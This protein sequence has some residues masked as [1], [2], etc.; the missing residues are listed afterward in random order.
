MREVMTTKVFDTINETDFKEIAL[1]FGILSTILSVTKLLV[2]YTTIGVSEGSVLTVYDY[3]IGPFIEAP[4]LLVITCYSLGVAIVFSKVPVLARWY[5]MLPITGLGVVTYVFTNSTNKLVAGIIYLIF[6]VFSRYGLLG[7][8]VEPKI[9]F[10]ISILLI[11]ILGIRLGYYKG[12][13]ALNDKGASTV[14]LEGQGLNRHY[15]SITT[16]YNGVLFHEAGS[17]KVQFAP[18]G[19]IDHIEFPSRGTEGRVTGLQKAQPESAVPP[20]ATQQSKP[21]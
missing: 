5:C 13:D 8:K 11:V 19:R 4:Y 12:A 14:V 16:V 10:L 21:H 18:W 17:R 20:P 2:F 1:Y 7:T 15:L 6:F 3:L 9:L